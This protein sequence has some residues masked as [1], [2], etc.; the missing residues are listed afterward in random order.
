MRG[1]EGIAPYKGVCKKN[2]KL[3]FEMFK[4]NSK[5]SP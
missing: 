3:Q 1:D 4:D 2:D 5:S